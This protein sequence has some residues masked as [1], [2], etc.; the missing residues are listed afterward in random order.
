MPGSFSHPFSDTSLWNTRIDSLNP[1]YTDASTVQNVQF[2]DASLAN[3]WLQT[4]LTPY[5]TPSTAPT[6]TWS[7][8]TLN[9]TGVG[10]T[11]SSNGTIQLQTP[12]DLKFTDGG[13]G[14]AVFT[15][16]DGVHS[17]E[18]WGGSYDAAT[19]TYHAAYLVEN[20]VV[21]GT[22][23]GQPDTGTGVGIRAA[24]A[25]LLGGLVTQDEL[26]S[27]SIQH[28]LGI[29][30][31]TH[32]LAAAS[33]STNAGQ[34]VFPAVTADGDSAASY[35]GTIPMGAHFALPP[36]LDLA[37]AGLTPEGLA[38]AKAYQTYGG[39]VVDMAGHTTALAQVEATPEQQAH[40]FADVD[41]I[42]D[43][44]VMTVD[45]G[46]GASNTAPQTDPIAQSDSVQTDTQQ[47]A[48]PADV[49][50]GTTPAPADTGSDAA[51]TQNALDETPTADAATSVDQPQFEPAEAT[52]Q[53][54]PN[55]DVMD[56]RG[57]GHHHA[58]RG[59]GAALASLLEGSGKADPN[60][61]SIPDSQA[62][63]HAAHQFAAAMAHSAVATDGEG[64]HSAGTMPTG[65]DAAFAHHHAFWH[66]W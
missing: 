51:M 50:G 41:W 61:I 1:T 11:F 57:W 17:W 24:G 28:A 19:H 12:T 55:G 45:H 60:Q 38:L 4:D 32:Q 42:R 49:A 13:D 65:V 10:G 21:N 23:W 34:F 7:F 33:G 52:S 22:G 62:N 25:S 2:R 37:A 59:M 35:T 58:G 64:A 46:S 18:V 16:P 56:A 3:S 36:D 39:Y 66:A 44:L 53:T 15:S 29:E 26:N 31:D 47:A 6:A 40:L 8:D 14:W 48:A 27:L 54:I 43:H 5:N 63:E 30:L 20:D 9:T